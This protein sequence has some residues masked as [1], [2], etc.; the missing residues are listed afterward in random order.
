MNQHGGES[1]N[2]V[3]HEECGSH[4]D[5]AEEEEE[6]PIGVKNPS[7]VFKGNRYS[8]DSKSSGRRGITWYQNDVTPESKQKTTEE[9]I[10][11]KFSIGILVTKNLYFP[12]ELYYLCYGGVPKS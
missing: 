8:H 6:V 3:D 7:A 2:T 10:G 4:F 1:G 11:K 5:Q 9:E 12:L